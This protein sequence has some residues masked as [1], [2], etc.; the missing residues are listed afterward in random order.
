MPIRIIAIAIKLVFPPRGTSFVSCSMVGVWIFE[1]LLL[2]P[3]TFLVP[4]VILGE[5]EGV[6][7]WV[8][9]FVG[10][11]VGVDVSIGAGV[12]VEATVGAGL[13]VGVGPVMAIVVSEDHNGEPQL[14]VYRPTL[15]RYSPGPL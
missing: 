1:L 6:G 7:F 10:L 11:N 3:R 5:I 14:E 4:K 12:L 2:S 13:K 15:K 9:V 8:G